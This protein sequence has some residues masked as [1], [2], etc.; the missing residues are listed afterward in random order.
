MNYITDKVTT[1]QVEDWVGDEDTLA[2][3][4]NIINET[5][6]GSV[7]PTGV[8]TMQELRE[9]ILELWDSKK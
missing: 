3:L 8:L 5:W 2:F 1:K 6:E 9:D 4:T 7:P